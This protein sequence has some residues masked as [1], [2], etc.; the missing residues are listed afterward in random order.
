VTDDERDGS[1][2]F[3]D[4][5]ARLLMAALDETSSW[6]SPRMRGRYL[7]AHVV[8]GI[9]MTGIAPES[10]SQSGIVRSQGSGHGETPV[11]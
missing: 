3:S 2:E 8:R 5:Y 4:L 9:L 11:L 6:L 10:F 7:A 1:A